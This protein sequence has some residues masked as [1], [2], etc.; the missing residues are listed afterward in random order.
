ME[1]D[2]EIQMDPEA[3]LPLCN[4]CAHQIK[5]NTINDNSNQIKNE[6]NREA[7]L[8]WLMDPHRAADAAAWIWT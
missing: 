5:F 8:T 4:R 1:I 6:M 2:N 3:H 7:F